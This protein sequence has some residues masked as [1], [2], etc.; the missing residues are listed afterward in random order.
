MNRLFWVLLGA[1]CLVALFFMAYGLGRAALET[2]N[3]NW[4]D[5]M[6]VSPTKIECEVVQAEEEA[7]T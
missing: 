6:R 7:Q 1:A 2:G 5:C 3:S 4:L